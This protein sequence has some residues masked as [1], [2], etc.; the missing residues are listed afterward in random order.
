MD[1][2]TNI[3]EVADPDPFPAGEETS[4]LKKKPRPQHRSISAT[5]APRP[6]CTNSTK[7]N[8]NITSSLPLSLRSQ[9]SQ[10]LEFGG[11]G[12]MFKTP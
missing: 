11:L 4:V 8:H 5:L 12:Q 7:L 2:D 10:L 9:P 1:H 6:W 3:L